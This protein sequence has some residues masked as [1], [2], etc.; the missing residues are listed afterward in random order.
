VPVAQPSRP[1]STTAQP[2]SCAR[3]WQAHP[4]GG[5][6][7]AGA[8]DAGGGGGTGGGDAGGG[9]AGGGGTGG[10][11]GKGGGA[12]GTGG[13]RSSACG[14][15]LD[16]SGR[17]HAFG[18]GGGLAG[19]V[20]EPAC[21]ARRQERNKPGKTPTHAILGSSSTSMRSTRKQGAGGLPR[22]RHAATPLPHLQVVGQRHC[23]P[24]E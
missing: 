21:E 11:G 5:R 12:G 18:T 2:V 7:R 20:G 24:G 14:A 9:D 23:P 15:G 16:A 4:R 10:G 1:C 22:T 3:W 17:L 13:G 8:S 6:R 19:M